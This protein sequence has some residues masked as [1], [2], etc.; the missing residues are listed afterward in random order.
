M[1]DVGLCPYLEREDA[2][3]DSRLTLQQI[4][5]AF[6]YCV[7]GHQACR[8]FAEIRGEERGSAV[9]SASWRIA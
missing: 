6:E 7:C 3:C 2:R 5:E 9:V 4:S 8:V 1:D